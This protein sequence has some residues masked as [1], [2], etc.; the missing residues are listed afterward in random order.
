MAVR[1]KC[2]DAD[3][4]MTQGG[5]SPMTSAGI[6]AGA[7]L[8]AGCSG[9]DYP[10][11]GGPPGLAYWPPLTHTRPASMVCADRGRRPLLPAARHWLASARRTRVRSAGRRSRTTEGSHLSTKATLPRSSPSNLEEDAGSSPPCLLLVGARR[12]AGPERF[13]SSNRA[14]RTGWVKMPDSSKNVAVG[15]L[16]GMVTM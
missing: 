4:C 15:H 9:G 13:V 6:I 16:R 11:A 8:D 3:P 14:A 1:A 2:V 7:A 10:A 12:L 5:Y